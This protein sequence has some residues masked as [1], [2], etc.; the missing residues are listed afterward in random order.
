MWGAF[1]T[2][3]SRCKNDNGFLLES[4]YAENIADKSHIRFLK[5]ILVVNKH[6]SNVAVLSETGS[7]PLIFQ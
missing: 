4:I 3:T 5:Y 6:T 2:N 7:Y 1:K